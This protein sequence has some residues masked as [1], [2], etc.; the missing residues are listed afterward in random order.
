MSDES[1]H[2]RDVPATTTRCPCPCCGY[3]VFEEPPG[4]YDICPACGWEDDLAQLRFPR[5]NWGPNKVSLVE[6]QANFAQHGTSDPRSSLRRP[7]A[8][9]HARDPD[10]RPFDDSLDHPE[11]PVPGLEYGES[12]PDDPTT[13]YYWRSS[14]WR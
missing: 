9:V 5:M 14:F 13:L 12:Y 8:S 11:E 7:P 4:S 6:A 10:W 1:R 2:S 3:L